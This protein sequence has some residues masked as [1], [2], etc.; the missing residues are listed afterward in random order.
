[1]PL[2]LSILFLIALH[3]MPV[4]HVCHLLFSVAVNGVTDMQESEKDKKKNESEER[5]ST[6][7]VSQ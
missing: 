6:D 5:E 1:M 2:G 7:E 3:S 4:V